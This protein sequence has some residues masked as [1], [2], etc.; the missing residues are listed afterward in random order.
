MSASRDDFS[1]A[2]RS[3]LLQ[4]GAKQKFSLFFLICLSILIFLL[5][6]FPSRFMDKTRSFLNDSIYRVSSLATSPFK[7]LSYVTLQSKNHFS[8]HSENKILK[9]KI[10]LLENKKFES[11]YLFSENKKLKE[12]IQ[13]TE[14]EKTNSVLAKVILD[15]DSPFLKSIII[16]KGTRSKIKKGMPVVAGDYLVGRVVEANYLS[17][18]VL[19]LNDLNSKIPV[20]IEPSAAQAILSGYGET[21]P[22]LEYLPDNFIAVEEK[23]VFTSGK[24]GILSAGVPVGKTLIEGEGVNETLKVKLFA[25]PNQLSFVNVL[26]KE[27]FRGNNF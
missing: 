16:N 11:E 5:D 21:E 7:F 18:R 17:S 1:I 6:S 25:D 10:Y 15:K 19:L 12:I 24:D 8:I 13:S 23:T 26:V 9:E 2:I 22:T 20:T 3:A 27:E 14:V 4:K